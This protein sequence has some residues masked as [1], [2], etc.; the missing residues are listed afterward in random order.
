MI[1][2][3]HPD[4]VVALWGLWD[5]Y[6]HEVDG[7][8]L[9]VG[10]PAWRTHMEQTLE[11][12]LDIVTERGARVIVL[13]TPYLFDFSQPRVDDLNAVFRA[14]AAR[15]PGELTVVD[16]QAPMDRLH[17]QRWDDVHFTVTGADA[18]G[19]P[20]VTKIERAASR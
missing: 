19:G 14:V 15:R 4:L 16:I 13:T 9:V 11:H 2:R 12:A 20:V 10:T 1:D 5:L 17:P 18:L 6:D 7:R 3:V 8:W